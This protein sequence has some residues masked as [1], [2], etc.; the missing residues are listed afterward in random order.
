MNIKLDVLR[1]LEENNITLASAANALGM[2]PQN[3]KKSLGGN[4]KTSNIVTLAN[5]LGIHPS[6]FFYDL[7]EENVTDAVPENVAQDN[8]EEK[9]QSLSTVVLCPHCQKEVHVGV[10]LC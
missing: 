3:V 10:V 2:A 6:N 5:E 1:Y 8:G 7:D 9:E 4:P